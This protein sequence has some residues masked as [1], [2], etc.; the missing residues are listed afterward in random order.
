LDLIDAFHLLL[1]VLDLLV[2]HVPDQLR[3]V[4]LDDIETALERTAATATAAAVAEERAAATTTT[5][6]NRRKRG[7]E[8]T[9]VVVD[10][11]RTTLHYLC[12][13]YVGDFDEV[14]CCMCVCVCVPS[15]L[16]WRFQ[17]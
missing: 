1:C 17:C 14:W 6:A 3:R 13:Q 16:V 15:S 12:N 5:S 9:R 2:T 7:A 11:P 10:V 4:S 8:S